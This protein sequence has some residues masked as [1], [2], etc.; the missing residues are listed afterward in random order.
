MTLLVRVEKGEELLAAIRDAA[1]G[2]VL[3]PRALVLIGAVDEVELS[4]MPKN[5]AASDLYRVYDQPMEMHGTGEISDDKIHVH[6]TFAG[7]DIVVVGHVHRA[8]V[9]HHFVNVYLAS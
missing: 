2:R 8:I 7:E 6:A 3:A 4:V 5:N 1:D 9:E